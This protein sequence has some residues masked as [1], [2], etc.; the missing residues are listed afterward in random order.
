MKKCLFIAAAAL[1]PL[2]AHAGDVRSGSSLDMGSITVTASKFDEKPEELPLSLS[3]F[4]R[5]DLATGHLQSMG[6]I[7][8]LTPNFSFYSAGSRRTAL[9]YLRGIGSA[10]PTPPAVGV[11]LDDVYLHKTGFSDLE[12]F[13]VEQIEFLRGPQ[14]TLY[15]KNTQAGAVKI[16]TRAPGDALNARIEQT[17]GNNEYFQTRASAGTATDD[18]AVSLRSSMYYRER[19][20]YTHNDFL[21]TDADNITQKG[22]MFSVRIVPA[23]SLDLRLTLLGDRDSDG[24]YALAP[25]DQVESRPHHVQMNVPGSHKRDLNLATFDL[26]WTGAELTIRSI[27]SWT[28]W[29]NQD[30]YDADFSPADILTMNDKDWLEAVTQEIRI[31]AGTRRDERRWMIG[32]FYTGSRAEDEN[33]SS[34]GRDG[35]LYG[36]APGIAEHALQDMEAYTLAAFGH[37]I[38]PI[39]ERVSVRAGLR[40]DHDRLKTDR[41]ASH[42]MGDFPIPGTVTASQNERTEK[43]W[44]PE[45]AADCLWASNLLTYARIAKGWRAGGFNGPSQTN[46]R[47]YDPETSWNYEA[48]IKIGGPEDRLRLNLSAFFIQIEDQQLMQFAPNSVSYYFL[49]AGK[50]ESRGVE[51]EAALHMT[52][53]LDL[54]A[55]AGYADMEYTDA[56]NEESGTDFDGNRLPFSPAFNYAMA[57]RVRFPLSGGWEF[58]SQA[59][60]HGQSS[61]CWD[62]ANEVKTDGYSLVDVQAGVEYQSWTVRVF[63]KNLLDEEYAS[64]VYAFP[65]TAPRAQAGDPVAYGITVSCAF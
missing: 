6:D 10:G 41:T 21:D 30:I 19:D 1:T 33:T 23:D 9:Y 50:A 26:K 2:C 43:E 15:G 56:P 63:A 14:S 46:A 58:F 62:E 36:A 11:F 55:S 52:D 57:A 20:G 8:A 39:S 42:R 3:V 18:G 54:F 65:G 49:N 17:V 22:G 45:I 27:S 48:G 34:F 5:N 31:S 53:W 51:A 47:E 38:Q 12:L 25:L 7:A 24:G 35:G 28:D 4:T 32:A 59:G 60:I 13:D 37:I 29:S 64:V 44:T 40:Y 16:Q 61:T